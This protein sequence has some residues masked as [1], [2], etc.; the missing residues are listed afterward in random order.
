MFKYLK[1]RSPTSCL[2]ICTTTCCL[3]HHKQLLLVIPPQAACN[4]CTTTRCIRGLCPVIQL[5]ATYD[6]HC[7]TLCILQCTIGNLFSIPIT[8]HIQPHTTLLATHSAICTIG[9]SSIQKRR[10]TK[11]ITY[12]I[13]LPGI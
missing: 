1:L 4:A 11:P 5:P 2:Y 13:P 3:Y 8:I 6:P 9:K 12:L 10:N 7:H